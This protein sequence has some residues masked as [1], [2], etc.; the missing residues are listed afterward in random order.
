MGPV[1]VKVRVVFARASDAAVEWDVLACSCE[2][3]NPA[4]CARSKR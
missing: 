3:E 4:M 2:K 1:V